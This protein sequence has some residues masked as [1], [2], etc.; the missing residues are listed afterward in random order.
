MM[1]GAR[2][3]TVVGFRQS[4][5]IVNHAGNRCM[6]AANKPEACLWLMKSG[7]CVFEVTTTRLACCFRG[8]RRTVIFELLPLFLLALASV[9]RGLDPIR[10]KSHRHRRGWSPDS[11]VLNITPSLSDSRDAKRA[12]QPRVGREPRWVIVVSDTCVREPPS[13]A[14]R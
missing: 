2:L 7:T 9:H 12:A 13:A 11:I 4:I 1:N 5:S 3:R 14:I 8:P 6:I 10:L